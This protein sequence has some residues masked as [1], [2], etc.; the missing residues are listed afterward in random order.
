MAAKRKL[1]LAVVFLLICSNLCFAK[2]KSDLD[3]NGEININDLEIFC[4]H[5]LDLNVVPCIGDTDDDCDVDIFDFSKLSEQWLGWEC[6]FTATASSIE[7][8]DIQYAASMAVDNNFY[9]R[10]SSIWADNQWILI[11]L[12]EIKSFYGL[13]IYWETAYARSYDIQVSNDA[14]GWTTVYSTTLGNGG[15]PNNISFGTQSARYVRIYCYQRATEWGNSIWEIV[16][17]SDDNCM[18]GDDFE[19]YIDNLVASMTLE[20]K[21]SFVHGETSM[22]LRAIPRLGIP[23]LNLA[24]GPLGIRWGQA[25]AFPASIALSS[26]WDVDLAGRFGIA[27][28]KEWKNKGRHVWLGPCMNIVRVPHGGRNFETYGEDPY[29]NSRMAVAT[30]SGAQSENIIACAKHYAANNQ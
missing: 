8:G 10:W 1:F 30:I 6:D 17:K 19:A 2:L 7:N 28:G 13:K 24:D 11:D 12:G 5:W 22:N 15:Y 4:Q 9:T 16:M 27:M 20:E 18:Y 25:T 21:T 26:S 3:S 23:N 14:S 29:L